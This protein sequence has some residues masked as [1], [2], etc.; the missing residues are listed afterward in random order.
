MIFFSQIDWCT[1]GSLLAVKK[2]QDKISHFL[3]KKE[4][5]ILSLTLSRLTKKP[6]WSILC[7]PFKNETAPINDLLIPTIIDQVVNLVSLRWRWFST[8]VFERKET[9]LKEIPTNNKEIV[10]VVTQ[11]GCCNYLLELVPGWGFRVRKKSW[12]WLAKLSKVMR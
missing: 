6:N 7:C 3:K 4:T 12:R 2:S 5:P 10:Y 1:N 11:L 9:F 8:Q